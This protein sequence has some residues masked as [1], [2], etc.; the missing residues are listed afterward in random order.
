MTKN[1]LT[2]TDRKKMLALPF[3]L[4]KRVDLPEPK[5]G[6]FEYEL[7]EEV[8]GMSWDE[9][10]YT[11]VDSEFKITEF[12]YEDFIHKD[13]L[14]SINTDSEEFK[15]M[16]KYMNITT[17]TR[18]EELQ[19]NKET[20]KKI[21]PLLSELKPEEQRSL[22]HMLFSESEESMHLDCLTDNRTEKQFAKISEAENYAIKNRYRH[23]HKTMHYADAKRM[24]ID[25]KKVKDLLR[26]QHIFRNRLNSE[27]GTYQAHIENPQMENGVLSFLNEAAWGEMKDLINDVGIKADKIPFYNLAV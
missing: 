17:K 8:F 23:Q 4:M 18:Y 26:N 6:Q 27:I 14:E 10:L 9:D 19:A 1:N 16:I 25:E 7:F 11:E 21:M 2:V 13:V 5:K 3:H 12:N 20:F 24:P 22:V 15:Q